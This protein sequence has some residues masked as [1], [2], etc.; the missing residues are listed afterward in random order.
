MSHV[1]TCRQNTH[2]WRKLI[3]ISELISNFQQQPVSATLAR[4]GISF[5]DLIDGLW[6]VSEHVGRRIKKISQLTFNFLG[7]VTHST[8]KWHISIHCYLDILYFKSGDDQLSINVPIFWIVLLIQR[9]EGR[10]IPKKDNLGNGSTQWFFI[11][12]SS[13]SYCLKWLNV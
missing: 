3:I 12:L 9:C 8:V 5:L 7:E 10:H 11:S 4:F 2:W 6:H 13:I 1:R